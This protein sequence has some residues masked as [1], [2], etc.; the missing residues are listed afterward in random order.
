MVN[1]AIL[2]DIDPAAKAAIVDLRARAMMRVVPDRGVEAHLRAAQMLARR[3]GELL[4]KEGRSAKDI[5]EYRHTFNR[6]VFGVDGSSVGLTDAQIAAIQA[7][8]TEDPRLLEQCITSIQEAN[9]V[10]A[11]VESIGEVLKRS[12]PEMPEPQE[13]PKPKVQVEKSVSWKWDTPEGIDE[14]V[15]L[16]TTDMDLGPFHSFVH[17]FQKTHIDERGYRPT[18][19]TVPAPQPQ[20]QPQPAAPQQA[21]VQQQGGMDPQ[22]TGY[23]PIHGVQMTQHSNA[24][25]SWYSHKDSNGNWCRGK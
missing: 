9:R 18:G 3:C 21:A 6:A 19:Y 4:R 23:C 10:E 24:R 7:W 14:L 16:R 11:D 2:E 8:L 17:V 25:G 22:V 13:D 15:T 12:V 1:L 20:P 5:T